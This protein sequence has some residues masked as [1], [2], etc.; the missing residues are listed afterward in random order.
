[1][2]WLL[3]V[4]TGFF[5]DLNFTLELVPVNANLDM[6]PDLTES[7]RERIRKIRT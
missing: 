1:M 5:A 6:V 7:T 3:K 2:K 4:N